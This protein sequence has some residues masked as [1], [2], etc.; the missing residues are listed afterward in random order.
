MFEQNGIEGIEAMNN[1]LPE[2]LRSWHKFGRINELHFG[3]DH[4]ERSGKFV[5]CIYMALTCADGSFTINLRLFNVSG[6][7]SF[8]TVN[9]FYS[10]LSIDDLTDTGCEKEF[11]YRIYSSEQDCSFEPFCEEIS[12][13]LLSDLTSSIG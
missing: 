8:N 7:L 4:D 5:R 6:D 13:E 11:R 9:G 3:L 10:G 12:T 2:E 1:V